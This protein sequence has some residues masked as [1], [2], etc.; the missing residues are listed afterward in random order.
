MLVEIT[1]EPFL[2][3]TAESRAGL[4]RGLWGWSGG[5]AVRPETT[6]I[7]VASWDGV[8]LTHHVVQSLG[9]F[10]SAVLRAAR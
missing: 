8:E 4:A 5:D 6:G 9:V 3:E 7:A 10:R 2:P 1:P